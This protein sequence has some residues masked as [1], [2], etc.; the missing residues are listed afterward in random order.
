MSYG[1][2]FKKQKKALANYVAG[3]VVHD[4]G[5]GDCSLA[6]ELVALGATKVVAVDRRLMSGEFP[7]GPQIE[8]V[9]RDFATYA[10]QMPQIDVAFMSWPD[11]RREPS[12]YFLI[13]DAKTIVYLGK[14]TD[15]SMCGDPELF[16]EL[17]KRK[18]LHY[19]PERKNT[20]II[21][22]ARVKTPRDLRGEE[23]AGFTVHDQPRPLTFEEI[24]STR[25]LV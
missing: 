23:I 19:L 3:H 5:A 1:V 20:L 14:N 13:A 22:G 10:T 21:Y 18:I 8:L 4:L 15:G 2:L 25:K 6:Q 9:G 11:K 16:R 24:E 7:H 12:L 17:G